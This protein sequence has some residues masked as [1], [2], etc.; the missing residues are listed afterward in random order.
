MLAL[1]TNP[2]CTALFGEFHL[3]FSAAQC[4]Y[5][6]LRVDCDINLV[7]MCIPLVSL[8][9]DCFVLLYIIEHLGSCT[10]KVLTEERLASLR[11]HMEER[12]DAPS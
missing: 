7:L 11:V 12:L 3:A 10:G 4:Y 6:H 5:M 9:A 1:L 2:T 8:L